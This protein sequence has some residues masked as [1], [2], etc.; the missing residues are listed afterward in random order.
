M[1]YIIVLI[2][3]LNLLNVK[4]LIEREI[5]VKNLTGSVVDFKIKNLEFKISDSSD[6]EFKQPTN[7]DGYPVDFSWIEDNKT[8]WI[9]VDRN[10]EILFNLKTLN[11]KVE[12]KNSFSPLEIKC[13]GSYKKFSIK[14][15]EGISGIILG[16]SKRKLRRHHK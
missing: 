2:F 8:K 5:F 13:E 7:Y 6:G 16:Q 14:K 9:R 15:E 12:I 11:C 4:C 1:K 3:L 10:F